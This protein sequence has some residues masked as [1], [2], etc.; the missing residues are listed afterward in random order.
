METIYNSL[1]VVMAVFSFNFVLGFI[2]AG[3]S[4]LERRLIIAALIFLGSYFGLTLDLVIKGC[5]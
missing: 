1:W 3:N 4:T 2:H 5:Q